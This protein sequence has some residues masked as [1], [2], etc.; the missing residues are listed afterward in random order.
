MKNLLLAF[1][2]LISWSSIDAQS[3]AYQKAIKKA[4][5]I[6][7]AV[8]KDSKIPGIAVT[9][10]VKGEIAWS[11]GFGYADLEQMFP[12]D[13]AKTKFRIGS[14]SKPVTA[15]A[16]ATLYKARKTNLLSSKQPLWIY[17]YNHSK[18]LP[19]GLLNMVLVG[20]VEKQTV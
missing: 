14:V 18:L 20:E 7:E 4:C 3:Q 15:A 11:E 10:M 5:K 13:P 1:L 12:V 8:Q 6:A 9:V 2:L 17:G 19:A 16:L